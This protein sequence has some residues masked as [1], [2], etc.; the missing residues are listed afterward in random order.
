MPFKPSPYSLGFSPLGDAPA[1]AQKQPWLTEERA[2]AIATLTSTTVGAGAQIA[3]LA[4]RRRRKG[5]R[6]RAASPPPAPVVAAPVP[7][8]TPWPLIIGGALGL[9]LIGGFVV[10]KKG[11]GKG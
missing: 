3:S 8:A 6:R 9:A 11:K 7:A 1:P 4:R 10:L 2:G 5:R